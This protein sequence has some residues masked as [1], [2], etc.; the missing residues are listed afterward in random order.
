MVVHWN[1]ERKVAGLHMLVD[2]HYYMEPYELRTKATCD[3]VSAE[4]LSAML[5]KIPYDALCDMGLFFSGIYRADL[6]ALTQAE[7]IK[8]KCLYIWGKVNPY[9][10]F[11]LVKHGIRT[12]AYLNKSGDFLLLVNLNE[13]KLQMFLRTYGTR[14]LHLYVCQT[15]F[16]VLSL[17][18]MLCLETVDLHG[19]IALENMQGL[20]KLKQLKSM[21]ITQC[22]QLTDL[23]GLEQLPQFSK[24]YVRYCQK[25]NVPRMMMDLSG[26]STVDVVCS[27]DI[28]SVPDPKHFTNLT[29]LHLTWCENLSE[30]P[31]LSDYSGL[32]SFRL[33]LCPR[34]LE[35]KAGNT[36]PNL[37]C[38]EIQDCKG[39]QI[40]PPLDRFPNLN[41]LS[42][43]G[44][45]YIT[46]LHLEKF[47]KL[48]SLC[49]SDCT[50][51]VDLTGLED[52]VNMSRLDL[53][54]CTAL[55]A[56]VDPRNLT[57]LTYLNLARCW[58][59]AD[60]LSLRKLTELRELNL[61]ECRN[62]TE[63]DLNGCKSLEEVWGLNTLPLR[64]L[65]AGQCIELRGLNLDSTSYSGKLEELNLFGCRNLQYLCCSHQNKLTE[66]P[67]L[68][69]LSG[70]TH[71]NLRNA[72]G[73]TSLQ[74][75]EKLTQLVS[76]NLAGCRSLTELGPLHGLKQMTVLNLENCGY[77]KKL[78]LTGCVNLTNL[79]GLH[80]LQLTSV[81]FSGCCRLERMNFGT[82]KGLTTL[83]GMESLTSLKRMT[84]RGASQIS[85]LP[86]L[87]QCTQ[88]NWLYLDGCD[89]LTRLPS[90]GNL[91]QLTDLRL[92]GLQSLTALPGLGNL[93]ELTQLD[94]RNCR[95]LTKLPGLENLTKLRILNLENC[96]GLTELPLLDGFIFG[97][98][99][100]VSCDGLK[101]IGGI[102]NW[103]NLEE[104]SFHDCSS[105]TDIQI[106]RDLPRLWSLEFH[107][108]SSL[109]E[110]PLLD[111]MD[112]LREIQLND[113]RSLA[114]I[115]EVSGS[116]KVHYL[117][118]SNCTN[119]SD[120]SPL[121]RYT[122]LTELYFSG[123]SSMTEIPNLAGLSHLSKIYLSD[124]SGLT[125]LPTADRQN[126]ISSLSCRNCI[127]LSDLSCLNS[128]T[129]LTELDLSGCTGIVTWP[130]FSRLT[131]LKR[132]DLSGTGIRRIPKSIRGLKNLDI[133]NLCDLSLEEL[134][135]W[136]PE[137]AGAFHVKESEELPGYFSR[138]GK[139]VVSLL[140]TTVGDEDMS[141][142]TQSYEMVLQWFEER[143]KGRM[144]PLNE[145]KVVFLGDGE[146]GKTHTIARL[147]N[148]GGYPE[149]F[150]DSSTP[151]IVIKNKGYKLGG[152]RIRV[153][154]WD[155][156]GQEIL[157][158]M[159]RIFLTKRTMYVILLNARDDTQSDRARYWLHN[160]KSFAPDAPV[161]LVL[162]KID[163]NPKASVNEQ[164]LRSRYDKLTKVIRL[165]AKDFTPKQ[166]NWEFTKVLMEEIY[167][168]GFLSASWPISWTMV[169]A[170]LEQM[171]G[172]YIMGDAY[173]AICKRCAVNSHQEELLH[174][175]NDLG[176][177]FCFCDEED[178]ALKDY[179]ILRPDWITNALYIILFN[180]CEGA[181]NGLVPHKAI[182]KLLTQVGS[183]PSIRC[184]LPMARY[185]TGDIHYV[186]GV[187]RKFHLSFP[188]GSD[189]E[190]IPMLCQQN[191]KI[192]TKSYRSDVNI[193]EFSMEFDYL[194][195]N[196]LHR[197]MVERNQELDIEN[198]WRTGARFRQEELG[199]S[200]VVTMDGN[201]LRFFIFHA[202]AMHRPN[203][204]LAML[205][206]NVDRIYRKMGLKEP[207]SQIIYKL[208]DKTEA[209]DYKRLVT[210]LRGEHRYE[211]SLTWN[212]MLD[213]SD[214]L[215]QASPDGLEEENELLKA[216]VK[217]CEQI[218]RE[219]TCRGTTEDERN[220]RMRDTLQN[221]G[222]DSHNQMQMGTSPSGKCAG[223]LD[224][225][226][227]RKNGTPWSV[228]EALR[229][230]GVDRR[231]WN[232]HLG[233]MLDHYNPH[234]VPYL[235]LVTY[236]DCDKEKY[237]RVWQEYRRQMLEQH[238]GKFEHVRGS[239]KEINDIA[240]N[241]FLNIMKSQYR[242][243]DYLPAVYHVFVQ[244]DPPNT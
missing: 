154:Y 221:F 26:L 63:L 169:K 168:T 167:K 103:E 170:Q 210:M 40:L 187:M 129:E 53:S 153:H 111:G 173:Q 152:R 189:H 60:S 163:Q 179:V 165:S 145:I 58:V 202:N 62:L 171:E 138:Q 164:D 110:L 55:T 65:D 45:K 196:L 82:M 150:D 39:L 28:I 31:E 230:S 147:M 11:N 127:G 133:L 135:E 144:V 8:I 200:A 151:G 237:D 207:V 7:W 146:A 5:L 178:Y 214:I 4:Q 92:R 47:P 71:M 180:E 155:F 224:L 109:T 77:L 115:P 195:N 87:E 181:A 2:N 69:T 73:I 19:N 239:D 140:N 102:R 141:I 70:L 114:R 130:D 211:F 94:L 100:F 244:I 18:R 197:L 132:L 243:G 66:L 234:G 74:G 172:H 123:C 176:V 107:N 17:D 51:L 137:I 191:S 118:C 54:S 240:P 75:I 79:I 219:P 213:I 126:S 76:L 89:K 128:Y 238:A 46:E 136:L 72:S 42:L 236:A 131:K 223:E 199:L 14:I 194:P 96:S 6:S 208:D 48:T 242:C 41:T 177:S 44:Y 22:D 64:K 24:L 119:L 235:F 162:N 175:F 84:L 37:T 209:F 67:G 32:H 222:Y 108:C 192:D 97:V 23:P 215:N 142:F 204:Y 158:S 216:V 201:I 203:T 93:T 13:S 61:T 105:L 9:A 241:H 38:L 185:T 21:N 104:L 15:N 101:T 95:S 80:T 227:Y 161:L 34:I 20:E 198:V 228:I 186:L 25:L 52:L 81:N 122:K 116:N 229:V 112:R 231:D 120:L 157:H 117:R 35:L 83:L 36:M 29:A 49:L 98:M 78:D 184:V 174:W 91:R 121:N 159:H 125:R 212:R 218:Q 188:Y 10:N 68:E 233:K 193:L 43:S 16:R 183:D 106:L 113:C 88:L 33:L 99:K 226:L 166:F 225:M 160:V 3:D 30:I 56:P 86:G 57:R 217:A 139:A 27:P 90:L 1:T 148:N 206:V 190:F 232:G 143:R 12:G 149:N 134:P 182:Y 85:E 220:R 205:K 50:K 156:G 124:C 59:S